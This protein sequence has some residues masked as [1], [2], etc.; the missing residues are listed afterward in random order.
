VYW[1]LFGGIGALQAFV[2]R[3]DVDFFTHLE[4]HLRGAS[5]ARESKKEGSGYE[6]LCS[7][8]NA[9]TILA[10]ATSMSCCAYC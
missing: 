8:K 6:I 10:S 3:E 4:M 9:G 7:R 5:G 2:S 1:T